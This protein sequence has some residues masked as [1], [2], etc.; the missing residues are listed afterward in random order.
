MAGHP[1]LKVREGLN[2]MIPKY[3]KKDCHRFR[4]MISPYIDGRI[5]LGEKQAL[6]SH[7]AS[8]HECRE[9]LE[10]LRTTV[11][12]LHRLPMAEVPRSFTVIESKPA[13]APSI[14]GRLC[15]ASAIVALVLVLLSA[16]DLFQI[17]PEKSPGS[18]KQL[19]TT[20]SATATPDYFSIQQGIGLTLRG[21]LPPDASMSGSQNLTT[22][23]PDPAGGVLD[24]PTKVAGSGSTE[25]NTPVSTETTKE[26]YR[27]PVHQIELA[28]LGVAIIMLF[29]V[30]IVWKKDKRL[31]SKGG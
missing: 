24:V 16:G 22:P 20:F 14:F 19:A 5:T 23:I 26:G 3:I 27:W 28:V 6:E 13:P 2:K 29:A 8:C 12:L 21:T 10:S 18:S 30:I 9:E 31:S 4:E 25:N 15:W 1:R 17:Y 11:G 7:L